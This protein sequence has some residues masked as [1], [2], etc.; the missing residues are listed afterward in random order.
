MACYLVVQLV[1]QWALSM[2]LFVGISVVLVVIGSKV[3][4]VQ[5]GHITLWLL[6]GLLVGLRVGYS[7]GPLIGLL[8]GLFVDTMAVSK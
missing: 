2:G 5:V 6:L 3:G 1:C 4:W 8:L 7:I